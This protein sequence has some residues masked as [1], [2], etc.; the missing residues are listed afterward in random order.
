MKI[1]KAFK[2]AFAVTV[3]AALVCATFA[4]CGENVPADPVTYTVTYDANGGTLASDASASVTVKEG[5]SVTL[6]AVAQDNYTFNGWYLGTQAVGVAGDTYTPTASVTLKAE[7][8]EAVTVDYALVNG[9]RAAEYAKIIKN[10]Y[11]NS[12]THLSKFSPKDPSAPYL[13]PYTEQ[14][15]MANGILSN[16]DESDEDYGFFAE[17]LEEL[18]DGLRFYRMKEVV[19]NVIWQNADHKLVA[20]GETDGTVNSYAIYNSGRDSSKKDNVIRD[21]GGIFFDDNI[22]VAKEFYYAYLNLGKEAYLN[23][24]I[25]IVNWIIGEGYET[26]KGLNG[27]YW[28]WAARYRFD[29]KNGTGLDDNIHASLNACS[30]APTAMMLAKLY[31]TLN[32]GEF[33]SGI[34]SLADEFFAK[35]GKLYEF[36]YLTLRNPDNGCLRDKIFLREGFETLTGDARIEL[37]DEQILP[38]NT[39]TLMTAGAELYKIYSAQGKTAVAAVYEKRNQAIVKD[40]DRVFANTQVMPGQYSYHENSWFT[41]FILEGFI[42]IEETGIDCS[43]YVEHM[44]S[45]L[46]YAWENYRSEEDQ[47]VCPAWIEGWSKFSKHEGEG[48]S[49]EILLQAANAH[50][51]AMLVRY[52]SAQNAE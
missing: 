30:S 50:C 51:Y 22:W 31:Q 39:G 7:W 28:N 48:S 14:V 24:A 32:A 6:P 18:L 42:D 26:A 29:Y 10:L 4:A 5:E 13:W 21:M 46:D 12:D 45:A 40:A 9:E 20:F 34:A 11:W 17:Y 2:K 1:M 15:A 8:E 44:R 23:E 33:S 52:Y 35:A 47:L 41:S 27:I 3:A 49:R 19:G 25:S 16:L 43:E 38:Y 37:V 36:C